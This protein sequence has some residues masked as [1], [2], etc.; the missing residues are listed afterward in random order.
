[1]AEHQRLTATPDQRRVLR[2][3]WPHMRPERRGI[4]LALLAGAAATATTVAVPAVIGAGVD[5]ILA[6]DRSGLFTAVAALTVLALLRLILFRQSELLLIA[7]GERVVRALRELAVTRLSRAPLRFLE[8]HPSGDLLRRTTTEIAD[9]AN[10]VRGQLPD[11]LTVAAYLLFTTVLL[12]TYSPLLTLALA[13]VFVPA[14]VCVLR[15]FKKA[16]NPAFAAEAAAA[17]TVATT[18][19][20]LVQSREMLQTGGG[21]GFWRERFLADN[22][23]RYRA[24][25]RSQRSLFLISLARIVQSLT[26]AVLL[27][28]GGWLAARGSISVGTVVVFILATRQLFDSATQASN[29]VG[30]VQISLVGLA[31]LLDLLSTTAPRA[32]IHAPRPAADDDG[33]GGPVTAERGVLEIEDLRYSYVAGT[34]VL[35][36]LSV[37]VEPG[38]RVGLV[39]PTGSGKTTLAK[40]MTGLY[41]PDSGTVRY[42]GHDLAALAPAE[43]RR[44]IVLIPQRVHMIEGTLLDNLRLVPGDPD[45]RSIAEAVER[46]GIADWIRSLDEGL[47]TDLGRGTGRLSAG[48]LQLIGL[49]RAALLDPAVLVLDEATADIDPETARTL[50]TAIDTLRADRTLIVIAHREAT[51]KRLPRTIRLDENALLAHN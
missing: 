21:I 39:G 37:R 27:L 23:R 38:E 24:A 3:A 26:T 51:I 14:I 31:R 15:L 30:Q 33:Q 34:E 41:A 35:G 28:A 36:G 20:E 6:R 29:L 10:F 50:E 40:L 4:T 2:R 11:V 49:V 25:R 18:Y 48:E 17:G 47:H 16:A 5:Q 19:R 8:A 1:M 46:L 32:E 7:V 13:L 42:D 12:L 22:E 9:L 44:R 45:E 43:L